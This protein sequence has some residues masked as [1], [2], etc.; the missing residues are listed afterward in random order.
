MPSC[1]AT[2]AAIRATA[3]F[4]ST[5]A[6][7]CMPSRSPNR[8]SARQGTSVGRSCSR[9]N[10]RA[11]ADGE[12][13]LCSRRTTAGVCRPSAPCFSLSPMPPSMPRR[14]LDRLVRPLELPDDPNERTQRLLDTEW[15][16]TNGLGG[17]ASSTLA[18]VIT[19]RY[20]GIL[21][22]ALPNPLG[23]T[24]MLNH[25][26]EELVRGDKSTLLNSE[27]RVGGQ[28]DPAIAALVNTVRLDGGLP[29][30]EYAWEGVRLEK[31]VFMPH[32]Q[33][34]V[35]VTYR[36]LDGSEEA[37][38]R[39]HPAV[40]FRGY[41]DPVGTDH[42]SPTT[43]RYTIALSKGV[44]VLSA[45]NEYPP[46]RLYFDGASEHRFVAN[47]Q[48]TSEFLYPVEESRGYEFRGSLW[49]PGNFELDLRG[50]A[51]VT[52]IASVEREEIMLALSPDEVASCEHERRR[53]LVY[54]AVPQAQ[55]RIGA[56]LVLAAD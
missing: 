32:R 19:R 29:V 4:S 40:H 39:L 35:H 52:L 47:E 21:V 37:L 27:R 20:H 49:R 7:G 46:L 48:L 33:N 55:D 8:S 11:T 43:A 45:G 34:T 18:G 36:L 3:C 14:L 38:L 13:R 2:S 42:A 41:E 9:P 28:L 16:V 31:R 56:E 23:R 50:D 24:V 22:A 25:L 54:S 26:G 15:L 51:C 17:Y 30:W 12:R 5:L 10:R 53:R 1:C 6:R 44:Q